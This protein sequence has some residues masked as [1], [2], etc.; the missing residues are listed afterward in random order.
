MK[1]L[2]DFFFESFMINIGHG[3]ILAVEIKASLL[4]IPSFFIIQ[5][6]NFIAC[7]LLINNKFKL[8]IIIRNLLWYTDP[9]MMYHPQTPPQPIND[10][11]H[12]FDN[13][14]NQLR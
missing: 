6:Y 14:F 4:G 7:T 8:N 10:V 3:E 11:I 13:I 12:P 2:M 1:E 5:L 9:D